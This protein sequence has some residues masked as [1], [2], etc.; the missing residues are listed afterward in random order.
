MDGLGHR[1]AMNFE[2]CFMIQV[3]ICRRSRVEPDRADN[4]EVVRFFL[5]YVTR[6]NGI[7]DTVGDR[8]AKLDLNLGIFEK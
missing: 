8:G 3:L 4:T 1:F 7:E 6:P 2:Q 5:G